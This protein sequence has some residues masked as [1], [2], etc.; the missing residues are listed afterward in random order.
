MKMPTP[1][2]GRPIY[3]KPS[4][5][6]HLTHLRV[7]FPARMLY[8]I[9]DLHGDVK[10]AHAALRLLGLIGEE[11]LWTGGNA[12]L[13]QTG[14]LVDR[15]PES[16]ALVRYFQGLLPQ[17]RAAGGRVVTLMGNHEALNV[18]GDL[19]FF[20]W[21]DAKDLGKYLKMSAAAVDKELKAKS[22]VILEKWVD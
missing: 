19:R 22:K 14:D 9:G 1:H 15:G 16:L 6:G 8:A 4:A 3:S 5:C 17:A 12:T 21:E 13:I 10:Q 11:N 7:A 2:K 20:A 18:E